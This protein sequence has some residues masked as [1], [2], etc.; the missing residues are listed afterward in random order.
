[1][2]TFRTLL[3]WVVAW[4]AIVVI[5]PAIAA[6]SNVYDSPALTARL[7]TAENAIPPNAQ[8]VSVGL[9][10][11]LG[12]GWKTYWRSPGEV[13]IAPKIDWQGSSNLAATDL[14]WPA[15]TRFRAFGIENFGYENDVTFPI[16]VTLADPGRDLNLR[17]RVSVLVCSNVCVP[18]SFDLE[19]SL[20]P[21]TGIDQ[22]AGEKIAFWVERVPADGNTSQTQL[23]STA[24]SEARDALIVEATRPSG[25]SKPDVFPELGEVAFGA[26]DIRLSPDKTVLW[27]QLPI[28]SV[29]DRSP[30]LSITLT[31]SL[32][33]VTFENA[34]L[35]S[36]PAPPPFSIAPPKRELTT[37]IWIALI[38]FGGGVI[39]NAMPCVLPVLSVKLSS[40]LKS[41]SRSS[42][43]IRISFV[44]TALGTLV[45]MWIMAATVLLLQSLGY[46]VGWGTQFQNTYF[47]IFLF[48]LL[49]LFAASLFGIFE[50]SLPSSLNTRLASLGRDGFVGDFASGIFAAILATPCTAPLLGTA[51]AYALTGSIVDI[52]VVFTAMGFGLALPYL[53]IAVSPN[54]VAALPKPGRW[55]LVV[56]T[57]LGVLLLASAAWMF[58]VLTAVASLALSLS[59]ALALAGAILALAAGRWMPRARWSTALAVPLFL[60]SLVLPSFFAKDTHITQSNE[61]IEWVAFERSSIARHVSEGHTVFVDVTA[62]WC[63][64]CKA[65]KSLVLERAPVIE[66]LRAPSVIAMRADWTRPDTEIQ[67][68]LEANGRFGIPF[69]TVY[70]PS[71]PE[72]LPLSE[73]LTSNAVMLALESAAI[74]PLSA[75]NGV[76]TIRIVD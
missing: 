23:R 33:A 76:P 9:S 3:T 21:G 20:S 73:V 37:L 71:A 15:P 2:T 13:G 31:D 74:D 70:G 72:G 55:M 16:R 35:G 50:I 60:G 24:Y 4:V 19:L 68:Y 36:T 54:L 39:L 14:Y 69:N 53:M 18:L 61:P 52:F 7:I 66:A 51:I 32:E 44:S 64:T 40:V 5:T 10:L 56:K 17:A 62:D 46:A 29:S 49:G 34:T 48:F 8:T 27:A 58:W 59:V 47:L 11:E 28:L 26:P 43:H 12:D 75:P 63:L 1:M 65:N 57:G 30:P 42:R 22:A 67:A 38:A 6:T 45:F 25:W 41:A